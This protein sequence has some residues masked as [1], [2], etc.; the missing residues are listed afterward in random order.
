M[1]M[2]TVTPFFVLNNPN[3]MQNYWDCAKVATLEA[4]I[5][6][7]KSCTGYDFHIRYL[8]FYF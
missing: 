5:Y 2:V 4:I 7:K 3:L 6:N 1:K 8:A